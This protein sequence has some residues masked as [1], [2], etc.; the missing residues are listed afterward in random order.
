MKLKRLKINKLR[1]VE[2]CELHFS[3]GFNVLL[4]I[5]GSG[6]TTFLELIAALV[7]R[8]FSKFRGDEFSVE[9]DLA[10]KEGT[11][12]IALD[13]QFVAPIDDYKELQ[14]TV[15]RQHE[16]EILLDTAIKVKLNSQPNTVAFT[17]QY[18][19]LED[20]LI[21]G[22]GR[23]RRQQ[24]TEADSMLDVATSCRHIMRFDESLELLWMFEA[25][26]GLPQG[27][28][29]F[30]GNRDRP[31]RGLFFVH[32]WEPISSS[33]RAALEKQA[34]HNWQSW[35]EPHSL[36]LT[37]DSMPFL[38]RMA[39]LAGMHDSFAEIT[40]LSRRNA[41]PEG[42]ADQLVFG[43]L[44]FWFVKQD[45][46]RVPHSILS[47]GQKRLLSLFYC[48]DCNSH[49]VIA[50]ELTN[51]LH[52]AWITACLE[53]IGDRQAFLAGQNPLL[54]D[55]LEFTTVADVK[56]TF[57][58]CRCETNSGKERLVWSHMSDIDAERFFDAYEVGLQHVNEILL[59]RDLW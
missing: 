44:R 33:L 47:Y 45:A 38:A 34:E 8:N 17:N 23:L 32:G 51:G 37:K 36:T 53:A 27:W 46:S 35:H 48:L 6:K 25:N 58:H 10:F 5:N 7:S 55:E 21:N 24:A 42:S 57:I 9:Y 13:H 59:A 52:H 1:N 56:R 31:E 40:L 16:A 29:V 14:R 3:D 28:I 39:E 20:F 30:L 50:D 54:V 19:R 49:I 26:R 11:V 2:P 4:G 22:L 41:Q 15:L 12:E 43:N 18:T